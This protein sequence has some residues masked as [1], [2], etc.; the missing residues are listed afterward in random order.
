MGTYAL[1][2][3]GCW[4]SQE[5]ADEYLQAA[6]KRWTAEGYEPE[7]SVRWMRSYVLSEEPGGASL[8]CIYEAESEEAIRAHADADPLPVDE[9]IAVIDTIVVQPGPGPTASS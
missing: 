1:L 3:R 2:R 6:V 9:V 4:P 7:F 5:R 8:V